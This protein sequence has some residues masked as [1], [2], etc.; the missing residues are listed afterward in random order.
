M[1]VGDVIGDPTLL[2]TKIEVSMPGFMNIDYVNQIR[3]EQ[4]IGGGGCAAIYRGVI[5]DHL[6]REVFLLFSFFF[7][8]YSEQKKKKIKKFGCEEVA[9]KEVF[10]EDTFSPEDNTIRFEQEIAIMWGISSHPNIITLIGYSENPRC[11]I[12]KVFFLFFS[13][14]F[15]QL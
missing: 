5:L 14:S 8:E 3:K 9:L 2:N 13:L 6:L 11:I 10:D 15:C 1:I 7:I 12:T 4:K